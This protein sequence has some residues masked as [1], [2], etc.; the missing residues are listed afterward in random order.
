MLDVIPANLREFGSRS[1]HER[2]QAKVTRLGAE[3]IFT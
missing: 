1:Y 3:K 2:I